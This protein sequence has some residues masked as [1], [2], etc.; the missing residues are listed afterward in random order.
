MY[1]FKKFLSILSGVLLAGSALSQTNY[2]TIGKVVR[3]DPKLDNLLDKE[4]KIE[5][6]ASGFVWT[7]GPVWVKEGSYLLFNDIPPNTL[8]KWK[9]AEG[10]TSFLKQSGYTGAGRYSNE[11]GSNGM[12]INQKGELIACEHGDR[13]VSLMP[14]SGG[15][16]RTLA[17][18]YQGK[19]FNSPNDV[20]QK[21]DGSY[22]FTD[23]PYGLPQQENDPSR[24]TSI[25]GVYRISPDGKVSLLISD[26]TRPNGLAFSPDEKIL[27]VA[28]SDPKKAIL[29]AYPVLKDGNLGKGKLFFDATANVSTMK[30][31]PDGLKVDKN[32][33]L[34][35]TGPGGVMVLSPEGTLLGRIDAGE[36]TAN[37]AFGDDGST[38]Y[39]TADMYLCR[40]KTKT[41]GVGF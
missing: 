37:C 25:C 15:G 33:N 6:L 23:P 4:A 11:P 5:V 32:G 26:L 39:I 12:T 38:L 22:Y 35:A 41:K 2:P 17:D 16:K 1:P 13:R 7:E 29:M 19:R 24:E 34:F 10:I 20:V 31:L 21:S 18:N 28:Q 8:F 30:G 3:I 40:I 9:E 36:A 14:L 27:Y